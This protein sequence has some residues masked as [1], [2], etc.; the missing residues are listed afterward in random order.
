MGVEVVDVESECGKSVVGF[1]GSVARWGVADSRRIARLFEVDLEVR[2]C[3]IVGFPEA[4]GCKRLVG[5]PE[6]PVGVPGYKRLVEYWH[7]RRFEMVSWRGRI[8]LV[9][10][11]S[12]APH[13]VE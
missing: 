7:I 6:V 12:W 11:D 1:V 8:P 2:E 9:G 13:G 4:P 3:N 5:S 10:P